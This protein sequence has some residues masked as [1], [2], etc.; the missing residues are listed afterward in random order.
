[1]TKITIELMAE[2]LAADNYHTFILYTVTDDQGVEAKYFFRGG[3]SVQTPFRRNTKLHIK[4]KAGRRDLSL[5][6]ALT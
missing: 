6:P 2:K 1:M 4:I 3:P 5:R